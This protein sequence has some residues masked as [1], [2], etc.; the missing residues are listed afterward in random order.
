[1]GEEIGGV[2]YSSAELFVKALKQNRVKTVFSYNQPVKEMMDEMDKQKISF[3]VWK[4]LVDAFIQVQD[5]LPV[6]FQARK[7]L[8]AREINHPDFVLSKYQDFMECGVK[9]YERRDLKR[10]TFVCPGGKENAVFYYRTELPAMKLWEQYIDFDIA[11][12]LA[13]AKVDIDRSDVVIVNRFLEGQLELVKHIKGLG[14]KVVFDIDDLLTCLSPVNP[15]AS[16]Y[17]NPRVQDELTELISIVDMVTTTTETLK[18]EMLVF[19]SNVHILR[20]KIDLSAPAWN[21][22][23][24]K[25]TEN[26]PVVVCFIGG[27]T[28]KFDLLSVAGAI[29]NS[30]SKQN[31]L[32]RLCGYSKGGRK[33]SVDKEGRII[34]EEQVKE[35]VW[36][37]IVRAFSPLGNNFQVVESKP[38]TEYP[39]FFSDADIIIAPLEDNRFNRAKSE[40]K[41]IEAGA[42]S[43]PIICSDVEPYQILEHG[44]DGF[45]AG[46]SSKFG[47]YLNRLIADANLRKEMGAALRKKIEA[48]YDSSRQE[49]RR[50]AY[51]SL[52]V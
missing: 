2:S 4:G 31:V 34:N 1:V 42:Y 21:L 29:I 18:K 27:S 49:D 26:D 33:L 19:N 48:S 44:V 3:G 25:K 46:S 24:P 7:I 15:L 43:L 8:T 14:K 40:L 38:L 39:S 5:E 32:F 11:V 41:I 10:I 37:E 47:K 45:L 12:N 30:C 36:D 16:L 51:M 28:H 35:S 20:N 17:T 13:V 6:D 9:M 23:R 22:S 52:F 50:L